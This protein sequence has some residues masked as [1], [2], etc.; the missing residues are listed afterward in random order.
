MLVS[1][2]F[3]PQLATDKSAMLIIIKATQ[4]LS[5]KGEVDSRVFLVYHAFHGFSAI[6]V[7][8][9]PNFQAKFYKWKSEAMVKWTEIEL[10]P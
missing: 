2:A 7:W 6:T 1:V 5:K 10:T 8:T 4:D 3:I 9:K